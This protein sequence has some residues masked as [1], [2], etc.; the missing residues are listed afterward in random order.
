[1]ASSMYYQVHALAENNATANAQCSVS[2]DNAFGPQ[3]EPCRREFDFT[4]LFEESILSIA[5]SVLFLVLT[6]IRV[7]SLLLRE[8]CLT[9]LGGLHSAKLLCAALYA[10]LQIVL[11]AFWCEHMIRHSLLTRASIATAVLSVVDA[12]AICLLSHFEHS[13]SL[14]P[15]TLMSVYLLLTLLFDL[16]RSRTLW[17][18]A[19]DTPLSAIFTS[20]IA[21][22]LVILMLETANKR[23]Y[24]SSK[25][26]QRSPEELVGVFSQSLFIWLNRLLKTGYQKL[27]AP[28]D[29]YPLDTVMSS[30]ALGKYFQS[31]WEAR[32]RESLHADYILRRPSVFNAG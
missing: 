30:Q 6:C 21:I 14:R 9:R 20:S 27:L 23:H 32:S 12:F 15:S 7:R 24:M 28:D 10:C 31:R 26:Q 19:Q 22:K 11:F 1:M 18:A 2:A 3:V 25:D 5:P 29:L 13:R 17:L 4:L 16:A 8:R